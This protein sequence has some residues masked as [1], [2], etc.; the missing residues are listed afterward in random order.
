MC[1]VIAISCNKG[2]VGK[3]TYAVNIGIGLAYNGKKVLLLDVDGQADLSKSMG[4]DDPEML[5]YTIARAMVAVEM[6]S[7]EGK[8]DSTKVLL[9]SGTEY[10]FVN[11]V[12]KAFVKLNATLAIVTEVTLAKIGSQEVTLTNRK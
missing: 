10:H 2:G 9:I 11:L 5:D 8:R 6:D 4:V 1:K 3:T 12:F 7:V